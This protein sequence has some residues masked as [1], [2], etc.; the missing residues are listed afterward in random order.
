MKGKCNHRVA[1][2]CEFIQYTGVNLEDVT[3]FLEQYFYGINSIIQRDA[4]HIVK[5]V[6]SQTVNVYDDDNDKLC[7]L[8]LGIIIVWDHF[9]GSLDYYTEQTFA[10]TFGTITL[11]A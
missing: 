1:H 9:V 5:D 11:E 3:D 10:D 7:T 8:D 2:P 4:L 6:A